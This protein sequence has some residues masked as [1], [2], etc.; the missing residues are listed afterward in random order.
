MKL[1]IDSLDGLGAVD[2]SAAVC[3]GLRILRTLNEPS[4]LET[5]LVLQGSGLK[6]PARLGRVAV[7]NDAGTLLFTGYL[8]VEPV[9]VYA[10]AASEGAVYR[11]A[12]RAVSEEWL[13]D[14]Q[15]GLTRVGA[16]LGVPVGET[17]GALAGRLAEG[18][19]G[20]LG[21]LKTSGLAGGR[22]VGVFEPAAAAAWS[23]NAGKA[24]R[25]AYSSYR[26]LDGALTVGTA[27]AV[28]HAFADGDGTL[29]LGAL[30]TGAV[31][32]LA[33][34][35]SLT[36]AMEPT[37]YWTE[38]FRG[39]GATTEFVLA[40]EPESVNEGGA[41]LIDDDFAAGAIDRQTWAVG[42]S[43]SYF[44]L[45][46]AG[47]TVNGGNGLDGQT[48]LTAV[49]ALELG[50][51]VIVELNGVVMNPG[52]AGVL[53]GLY[54]GEVMLSNCFAGFNVRQ[55]GGNTVAFAMVNGVE[56]GAS[57]TLLA[58]HAYTLRLR[59]H[60]AEM[61]RVRQAYYAAVDTSGVLAVE[62][63]GSG[64]AV[65]AA[66]DLVF[67]ARD[68][69]EGSEDPVTVLYDGAVGSSPG[70]CAVVAVDS[71]QLLGSVAAVS[72]R[73][74]GSG[75]VRSTAA[76]TGVVSTRLIGAA[77]DGVD[78]RLSAGK[79]VF[80]NGRVPQ[81][82]DTVG[83]SYRGRRRAVARMQD[84]ASVAVEGVARWLGKVLEPPARSTED[85]ERAA[86]AVLSFAA[87]RAAAVAG[88]YEAENPAGDV[89]PGDFLS[90]SADGALTG[91][92]VRRVTVEAGSAAPEVLS[93]RLGFAN[94][95]AEGLGV[96]LSE[97]VAAD[98]L[99][100]VTAVDANLP[101]TARV[102]ANLPQLAVP[103]M[104]SAFLTVDAGLDPPAGG[105]FEVR[106][107]DG[108]FGTGQLGSGAGDLVLRSPV[109]GFQIPIA[110]VGERFFVRMYDGS[111]P[112]LYSRASSAVLTQ[113]P[114]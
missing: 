85:C 70:S 5:T 114:V 65:D 60:C 105:G 108:G 21:S 77:Y 98:A 31:K 109:R 83:V 18:A 87:N 15:A 6:V 9:R 45:G 28:T 58:G 99:L 29:S 33:N 107:H 93:Y 73:R 110:A 76:A 32:E 11:L 89:W 94:D 54:D 37:V 97:A 35:V 44:G 61:L 92:V 24:A 103:A 17:L 12:L 39:D 46:A 102:L 4:T 81:P 7:T 51:T 55:L 16:S 27:G 78:C 41:T 100:P 106:R 23:S 25:A 47:L 2:F 13:L 20:A 62:Q 86:Q 71:L 111:V 53:A 90:L 101:E 30:Q 14:R 19:L 96:T 34:D 1:L 68:L 63:F 112:P 91:V 88:T 38:L 82:G 80:F 50:G 113:L 3:G 49:D 8:T 10:G 48:T 56:M 84:T 40:G 66:M 22:A 72:V 52:S 67:E 79:V 75:W 74:T 104:S 57:F 59:L 43:G 69:A 95:W 36:G 26:A 64:Q 42:D